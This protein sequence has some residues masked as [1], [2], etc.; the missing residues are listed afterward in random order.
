MN[1]EFVKT[2]LEKV[3]TDFG[4]DTDA[5]A[6][7]V[8]VFLKKLELLYTANK[9]GRLLRS[10]F[11]SKDILEFN[12]YVFEALF[13]YDF[14]SNGHALSYEV[15]QLISGGSSIDFCYDFD[16]KRKLYFELRLLM[17]SAWIR[18]SIESQL[19]SYN[20]WSLELGG[21]DQRDEVIRL[22][23]LVLE[24]CQDESGRP[25]KF[26]EVNEGVYNFV[27]VNVSEI[28]LTMF[29][30]WD[31]LLATYGDA[32]FPFYYRLGV[33]GL[34]QQLSPDV[35][36]IEA[37][38]N[39][40]FQHFRETIHGVLF[41]RFAGDSNLGK[42]YIDRDLEYFLV[43]NNNLLCKEEMALIHMRLGSFLK[44]WSKR[45]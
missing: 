19:K 6:G 36:D 39:A 41:V 29:D 16:E 17:Q 27:V 24:K 32:G 45:S 10:L 9:Y 1:K 4:M 37:E 20:S 14:E 22:Q 18:S 11:S 5:W 40:R 23:R 31:C 25:I 33:F 42:L 34:F 3:L 21:E 44:K 13:A 38:L 30:R 15:K 35:S 8:S 12:S 28:Q 26:R 2:N 7:H 43:W